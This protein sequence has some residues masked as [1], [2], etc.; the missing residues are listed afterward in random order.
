[1]EH[2]PGAGEDLFAPA[3]EDSRYRTDVQAF[4]A[5]QR[6]WMTD[7]LPGNGIITEANGWNG[8]QLPKKAERVYGKARKSDCTAM[9]LDREGKAVSA[10]GDLA[11]MG[12]EDLI[13]CCR[14]R[15]WK[16]SARERPFSRA[17]G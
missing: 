5:A 13:A 2:R 11:N 17:G 9:Y 1:M 12:T 3:D 16:M 4:V 8:P 15:R 14:V 10:D 6:E 7:K